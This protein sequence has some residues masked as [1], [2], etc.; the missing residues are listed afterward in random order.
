[1]AAAVF[2]ITQDY[3]RRS[4]VTS[5]PEALRMAPGIHVARL[6]ANKWAITS[7]G[8]DTQFAD[9]LAG[10]FTP[11]RSP[12]FTGM[13]RTLCWKIRIVSR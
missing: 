5:I 2:V 9:K 11:V 6:D 4:G 10:R 3:I 13:P 7:R 8:F 12:V 1:V